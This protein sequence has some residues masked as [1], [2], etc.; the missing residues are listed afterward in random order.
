MTT[1]EQI[2]KTIG[3]EAALEQLAEEAAELAQAALKVS[4]ITRGVNPTPVHLLDAEKDLTEELSDVILCAY[5]A[6][7]KPNQNLMRNKLIRWGRR[8]R[9]WYGGLS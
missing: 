7:L 5:V 4:R 3:R 2:R 9:A 6:G 8:L 1:Y